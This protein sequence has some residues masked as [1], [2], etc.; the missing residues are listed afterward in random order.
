M[1]INNHTLNL[2]GIRLTSGIYRAEAKVVVN[3]RGEASIY[4]DIGEKEFPVDNPAPVDNKLYC[5]CGRQLCNNIEY[6]HEICVHCMADL[7]RIK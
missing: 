6:R 3:S 1:K 2:N 7:W 4:V 5:S